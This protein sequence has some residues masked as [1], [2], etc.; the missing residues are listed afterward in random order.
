MYSATNDRAG[1][2]IL[3]VVGFES[4]RLPYVGR[5]LSATGGDDAETSTLV[6]GDPSE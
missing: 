1:R 5:A 2:A 3:K 6:P 4:T